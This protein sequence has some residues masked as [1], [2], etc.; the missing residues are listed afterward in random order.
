[1]EELTYWLFYPQTNLNSQTFEAYAV[2]I[3]NSVLWLQQRAWKQLKL[4][5]SLNLKKQNM[6]LML[7]VILPPLKVSKARLDGN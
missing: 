2:I 6:N 4:S 3:A 1:M 7:Y 5:V